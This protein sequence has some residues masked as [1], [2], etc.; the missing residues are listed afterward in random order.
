MMEILLYMIIV[1]LGFIF[2]VTIT[3][4]IQ[5]ESSVIGT[6]LASGY[7]KRELIVHYMT[8]PLIV[9]LISALIGN[10]LGYTVMK[11]VC[12]DLYY[13]S[14]SL[15]TY[16]TVWNAEAFVKTTFIPVAMMIVITFVI[17]NRKL[18]TP[19]MDFLRRQ[20]SNSGGRRV[21]P[22]SKKLPFFFRW[23]TRICLKNL[24]AYGVLLVGIIF[25]NLLIFFGLGFPDI[26]DIFEEKMKTRPLA[27]YITTLK[28]P[29]S[30]NREDHKL[31]NMIDL[32]GF[33]KDVETENETAEKFSAYGLR[34][35]PDDSIG[36]KGE[37]ITLYG[38]DRNSRYIP[39]ELS[40]HEIYLSSALAD[41]FELKEGDSILLKEQ[42]EEKTY[43]FTV[44]GVYDY[45]GSLCIFMEKEDLNT[46]FDLGEGTFAGYFS[47]TAITDIPEEDVATVIDL[48][49][50]TKLSRQMQVSFGGMMDLVVWF[51][52]IVYVTL[53]YVLTKV[54]VDNSSQSIS[55]N[56]IMGY[57][58]REIFLLY[59]T[60][61]GVL[62]TV[63]LVGTIPMEVVGLQ[64]IFRYMM[65]AKLSGWFQLI[66]RNATKLKVIVIA[67]L[68]FLSVSVLLYRKI[69]NVPMDQALKNVE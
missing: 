24:P 20:T 53:I 41:K 12:A 3:S 9:T 28:L 26:L 30:M 45:L 52:V 25:A 59:F 36:Y 56:K 55:M 14:Y 60:T 57:T 13:A 62:F 58:D 29:D 6:L 63:L 48:K 35:L 27:P 40:N 67:I 64:Y 33:L 66:V 10:I 42:Y 11:D 68:S 50:L 51:A 69:V 1:I 23:Q 39:L 61:T 21:L 32:L 16:V 54:I 5:Q 38:V 22:L 31:E 2:A 46:L 17:L 65:I 47:E 15:P 37:G 7:S 44:S 43:R 19:I 18:D 8:M 4:T 49:A 34:S